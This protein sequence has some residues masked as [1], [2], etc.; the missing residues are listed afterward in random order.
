MIMSFGSKETEKVW[1]GER[2]RKLSLETQ[3]IGRR[4]LRMIN[5][6]VDI[7]DLRIPPANRLEKLSGN[8][9]E[10]HSIRINEQWRIIF[11]WKQ[12][13]ALEVQIT[14]YH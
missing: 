4:K 7:E 9:K 14:D 10:F 5:N 12:G 2:S 1:E 8:L 6:S 3:K 13:N 11:K